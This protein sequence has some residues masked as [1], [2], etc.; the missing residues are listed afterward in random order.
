MRKSVKV[1]GLAY[2]A[3]VS[4]AHSQSIQK[5]VKPDGG[6]HFGEHPPP[7]SKLVGE[8]ESLGTSGGGDVGAKSAEQNSRAARR[9]AEK[10]DVGT[11]SSA[12]WYEGAAGYAD[13]LQRQKSSHAPMLVYFRTDWCPHC[14]NFERLLE[15]AAVRSRL[16]STIKVRINPE[17]GKAEDALFKG[18]FGAAGFP[19]VFLVPSGGGRTRISHSGPPEAFLAQFPR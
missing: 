11:Y 5:W 17:L 9:A 18:D 13:A 14:R 4:F 8:T 2:L 15:S 6:I 19:S 10:Q 3:A 16:A 7:G 12:S 1:A